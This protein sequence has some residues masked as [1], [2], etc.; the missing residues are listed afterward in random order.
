TVADA[1]PNGNYVIPVAKGSYSVGVEAVDGSP[2]AAAN[3]S[4]TCQ[5]GNFFGQQNFTEEFFNNDDE[6]AI[7]RNPGDAKNVDVD[8]GGTHSGGNIVTNS[9]FNLRPFGA[10][11]NIG[12]ITPPAGGFIYAVAY[13]ASQIS[14]INPAGE[15]VINTGLFDTFVVD[16]SVP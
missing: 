1:I 2:V 11:T 3:I 13:P 9:V 8:F 7:E 10:R 15:I 16:A 4:F 5:I 6:A 12:F 14:A